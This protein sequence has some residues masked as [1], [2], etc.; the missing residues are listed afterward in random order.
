MNKNVILS[1]PPSILNRIF[2]VWFRHFR[3]YTK[4]LISNGLPAFIEPLFFLIALGLGL[5]QYVSNI[6]G[7]AYILF[8]ASGI[9]IPPSMF[10]ASYECTFGTFIRLEFDKVYDGMLSSSIN[11]KDLLVGEIL[12]AGTKGLFFSSCILI[13]ITLFGLVVSPIAIFAPIVGFLTGL[14]FATL[15]LIITSFVSNINHFSFYFS[16]FLTPMFFFSGIIFPLEKLPKN[17]VWIAEIFPLTHSAKIV[18]AFYFNN[19][20]FNL[21]Y[22]FIY[23]IGFILIMGFI[24]IKLMKRRLID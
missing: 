13:V 8:L 4:N 7:K 19:F 3:V 21:I 11:Y 24:A 1:N 10:T 14:M 18:R 9:M 2:S 16:G 12:F 5:G 23:T 15:S 20:N 6:N 22:D 17:I